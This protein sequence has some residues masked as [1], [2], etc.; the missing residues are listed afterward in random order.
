[1][2][3]MFLSIGSVVIVAGVVFGVMLWRELKKQ[4]DAR[5]DEE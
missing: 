1:M 5:N 2:L 3:L 4:I